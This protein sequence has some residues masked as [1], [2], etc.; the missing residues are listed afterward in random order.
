MPAQPKS[1]Q[2]RQSY[3]PPSI[4]KSMAQNMQ[5]NM[6]AHLQKYQNSGVPIP[7]HI[8]AQMTKHMQK[9]LPG[10]M[11]QYVDPYIQ[12]NVV[13]GGN[14]APQSPS[15]P[16]RTDAPAAAA[17]RPVQT[18][19]VLPNNRSSRR[20]LRQASTS[21]LANPNISGQPP[22]PAAPKNDYD[23]IMNPS[24]P[25]KKPLLDLASGGMLKKGLVLGGGLIILI[26][27]LSLGLS[28]LGS[29]GKAHKQRLI[30]I[31]QTQ[32]EIVRIAEAAEKKVGGRD[33]LFKISNVKLT[34]G[35]SEVEVINALSKRGVKVKD[36]V[37]ALGQN[38]KNDAALVEGEQT[39]RFDDT[40]QALLDEQLTNYR[41]RLQSAYDSS[42]PAE[43]QIIESAFNQIELL[44]SKKT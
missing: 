25:P 11:Q 6:P 5:R 18:Q 41:L 24:K 34:V 17:N 31:A 28:F 21:E 38:S 23:F 1:Y 14:N 44:L 19:I 30:E 3:I 16:F 37:L 35:S 22:N 26:I 2:D 4:Q 42:S 27:V 40:Y 29:A 13:F 8:E 33:L 10:H 20:S 36:K 43:Q 9:N 12:Q 15:Q 7:R 39:G 32:T